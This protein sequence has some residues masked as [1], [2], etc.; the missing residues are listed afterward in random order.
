MTRRLGR[1]L[2]KSYRSVQLLASNTRI[3]KRF[4]M[5]GTTIQGDRSKLPMQG[6]PQPSRE[7]VLRL[8]RVHISQHPVMAHKL[9]KLRDKNTSTAEF[10]RLVKEIGCLL[11]YEATT[12]LALEPSAIETPLC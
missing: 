4:Y 5:L 8:P 2:L 11:A 9:T 12:S 10:Y 6:I 7:D 1:T 3:Q